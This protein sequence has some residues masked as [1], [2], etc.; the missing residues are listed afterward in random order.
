MSPI[1]VRVAYEV[2]SEVQWTNAES[3]RLPEEDKR[4]MERYQENVEILLTKKDGTVIDLSNAGG[5]LKPKDGKTYGVKS[6]TLDEVVPIE[7]LASISVGGVAYAI[8]ENGG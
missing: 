4:Q 6:T 3:G 7:E 1:A 2:D 5:S 8:S